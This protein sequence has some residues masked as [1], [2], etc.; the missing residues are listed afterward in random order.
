MKTINLSGVWQ[1]ECIL[2]DKS[3]FAFVG[4]VPGSAINDLVNAGRLPND[5]F[6]RDNADAVVEFFNK[7]THKNTSFK[8]LQ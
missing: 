6:W 8:F 7:L 4:S 2:P 3:T 5:L 1:G